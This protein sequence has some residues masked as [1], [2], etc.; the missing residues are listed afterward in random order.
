MF[1]QAGSFAF[2]HERAVMESKNSTPEFF[3]GVRYGKT[4]KSIDFLQLLRVTTY[5][6]SKLDRRVKNGD[7]AKQRSVL[8]FKAHFTKVSKTEVKPLQ[9][10]G[11]RIL[12]AFFA[13]SS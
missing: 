13:F 2:T 10:F 5:L 6:R 7:E 1:E 3:L 8:L 12:G 4:G 9:R 11:V